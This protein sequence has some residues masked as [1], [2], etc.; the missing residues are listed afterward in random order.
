MPRTSDRQRAGRSPFPPWLHKRLP[1]RGEA[2]A[3]RALLEELDLE[4]VCS[5]A[6]CPNLPECF[7]R[8]TATFLILGDACTRSCRFCAVPTGP[9]GPP[10]DEE[11]EAVAEAAARMRLRHVVVTSVTRDDLPDGGA[12]H[13]ART[14]AAV[15]R[16]LPKAVVEVLVPDFRGSLGA[17]RTVCDAGP[18]VFNHNV[19]TVPRLYPAVRPEAD[20]RQSL[21]VLAAAHRFGGDRDRPRRTK[22][23]LMVGLGE[24]HEEVRSVLVDLREAG[25]DILTVGQYLAPSKQHVPVERFVEPEAFEALEAEA[26]GLGFAAVAAGPFVRSSYRAEEVF[27]EGAAPLA[28]MR[29]ASGDTPHRT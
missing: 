12:G 5:S 10:R 14:I 15:R 7:A 17:V 3:V 23:G 22:S 16:R 19:E 8:G 24:T 20:Y 18:D 21:Q 11:P 26:R 4:T 9:S 6:H 29:C 28:D 1:S 27:A 2:A 13:F 25:C